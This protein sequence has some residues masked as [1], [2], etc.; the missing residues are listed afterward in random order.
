ME[1]GGQEDRS[2]QSHFFKIMFGN[3]TKQLRIP[4]AFTKHISGKASKRVI[5]VGPSG[6]IWHV[7]LD[8]R[9]SNDIYL[10]DGWQDFV[11]DHSLQEYDFLV[12][13]YDGRKHFSVKIF[14]KT[15]CEREDA[16]I[17]ERS[18]RNPKICDGRKKPVRFEKNASLASG[19][20]SQQKSGFEDLKDCPSVHGV[21]KVTPKLE[22]DVMIKKVVNTA[23]IDLHLPNKRLHVSSRRLTSVKEE[24]SEIWDRTKSFASNNPCL[25]V[26]L[27]ASHHMP[28][29]FSKKYL[30]KKSCNMVLRDPEKR[31]WVVKYICG[32]SRNCLS[33]GW[34]AFVR[35]QYF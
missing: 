27:T 1:A 15:A 23:P 19:H 25:K 28:S 6:G 34:T 33:G 22:R 21:D 5:L 16:F 31:C 17:I 3:F 32:Q 9:S 4:L 14:D 29:A 24:Y 26:H 2:G 11:E 13:R 30:P 10:L 35:E 18:K 20:L 12:F 8:M 7:Q